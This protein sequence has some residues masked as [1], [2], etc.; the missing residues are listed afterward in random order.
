MSMLGLIVGLTVLDF[1][2][3]EA[4][5]RV[6]ISLLLDPMASFVTGKPI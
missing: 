6:R 1:I 2:E 5:N 4:K 3:P